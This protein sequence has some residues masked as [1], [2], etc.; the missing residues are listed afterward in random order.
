ML[1][2]SNFL[3]NCICRYRLLKKGWIKLNPKFVQRRLVDDMSV[4]FQLMT[5]HQSGENHYLDRCCHG[6]NK[7]APQGIGQWITIRESRY[8][9]H[10]AS[11][12]CPIM[13][14]RTHMYYNRTYLKGPPCLGQ[15]I[16][17]I[18]CFRVAFQ[19]PIKKLRCN[20]FVCLRYLSKLYS[21]CD[22]SWGKFGHRNGNSPL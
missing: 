13:L 10:I 11:N 8:L 2:S 21:K 3:I 19:F 5:L 6:V 15:W 4:L 14:Y 16:M 18:V 22:R 17:H 7:Y 20:V 9:S 12:I 1:P